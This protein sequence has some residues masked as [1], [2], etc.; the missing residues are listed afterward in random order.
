LS[1]VPY[2]LPKGRAG[3]T[4]GHQE[5][6]DG[7]VKDGLWDSEYQASVVPYLNFPVFPRFFFHKAKIIKINNC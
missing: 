3:F 4:Y 2:Y 7:I 1:N 5:A 6:L